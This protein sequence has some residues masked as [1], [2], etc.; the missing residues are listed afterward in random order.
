[1]KKIIMKTIAVVL[2]L[3]IAFFVVGKYEIVYA[4]GLDEESNI[5]EYETDEYR[6]TLQ[7]TSEWNTAYN[8]ILTAEN[9][10]LSTMHNWGMLYST[11]DNIVNP[12]NI[13]A[14]RTETGYILRNVGYNQDIPAK[15]TV[16]FGFTLFKNGSIRLPQNISLL[17]GKRVNGLNN[18]VVE[19]DII[20]AWDGGY[21]GQITITNSSSAPIE[22]WILFVENEDSFVTL[23]NGALIPIEDNQYAIFAPDDHQNILPG[24]SATVGYQCVGNTNSLKILDLF[25]QKLDIENGTEN[26]NTDENNGNDD[27]Q[28]TDNNDGTVCE[29]ESGDEYFYIQ[30]D[31]FT[32]ADGGIITVKESTDTISGVCSYD[33]V[34]NV[35]LEVYDLY[36]SIIF[37]NE[38]TLSREHWQSE[39]GLVVGYNR[40]VFKINQVDGSLIKTIEV[41]N[42]SEENSVNTDIDLSDSDDD[43]VA[44]YYESMFGTD[45][46]NPDTDGDGLTD[47]EEIIFSGTDPLLSDTDGNGI[48]DADEDTDGDELTILDE[49]KFGTSVFYSDTDEDGLSDGYEV[50]TSKTDPTTYDTDG[51]G[52]SD[53]E[54]IKLG[55]NPLCADSD[56][57]GVSD[58]EEFI[59][60]EKIYDFEGDG[61]LDS[62]E[63]EL[64]CQGSVEGNVFIRDMINLDHISTDLVGLIGSP[65]EIDAMVDFDEATIQF[66][67]D[68]SKLN[69]TNEDDLCLMWYDDENR[70]YV[71]LEDSVVDSINNTVSYTTTH[72]SKYMIVDKKLWLQTMRT[73]ISYE[74]MGKTLV[75]ENN[76][77]TVLV[78]YTLSY[79]EL[80]EEEDLIRALI[81]KWEDGDRAFIGY[82]DAYGSYT[83]CYPNGVVEWKDNKAD[84]LNVVSKSTINDIFAISTG[85]YNPTSSTYDGAMLSALQTAVFPY[86][87]GTTSGNK[88]VAYIFYSGNVPDLDNEQV[89]SEMAACISEAKTNG[90]VINTV[91]MG[92]Y[93]NPY[94]DGLIAQT[95]GKSYLFIDAIGVKTDYDSRLSY[96]G[97]PVDTDGDGIPDVYEINGVRIQNG[98]IVYTDPNKADTD[99]D[100]VS[101]FEEM[102]GCVYNKEY[103]GDGPEVEYVTMYSDPNDAGSNGR[104]LD[105]EYI[106]VTEEMGGFDY[107]PLS[108]KQKKLI[109][110]NEISPEHSV[111]TQG[112]RIHGRNNIYKSNI[113]ELTKHEGLEIASKAATGAIMAKPFTSLASD[114]LIYYLWNVCDFNYFNAVDVLVTRPNKREFNQGMYD[115]LIAGIN[116]IQKG[117]TITIAIAPGEE[118][119]GGF[120]MGAWDAFKSPD[121]FFAIKACEAR[122][123]LKLSFDGEKYTYDLKYYIYDYYD[124]DGTQD[125]RLVL[126][127]TDQQLFKLCRK[128]YAKFY[129]NWGLYETKSS[130]D[131]SGDIKSSVSEKIKYTSRN[132]RWYDINSGMPTE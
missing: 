24:E 114:F 129:Q 105:A 3:A 16:S 4:S 20:N 121:S 65:I 51:D 75:S 73:R 64:S 80:L 23:W 109:Y 21:I 102:G 94:L 100:G 71:L 11:V 130:I 36:D 110:E 78:D 93:T 60:Q 55:L 69:G 74:N 68:E 97:T 119:I 57:D 42:F 59:Q 17:Y 116:Y 111:D 103:Y 56:G 48:F 13:T 124:W 35:Q 1:M 81:N 127:V 22:D 84:A 50:K 77:L 44:N 27:N 70:K 88:K 66:Q 125:T 108:N 37:E 28:N 31:K 76:D 63:V 29:F 8:V 107:L 14:E 5:K 34:K 25:E 41:F 43:G 61:V 122:Q 32:Q 98:R 39:I 18:A 104:E 52:Y 46:M 19:N 131:I 10:T 49:I 30:D 72:F 90:I 47:L 117:E 54:E 123:V 9:K 33:D 38:L 113:N 53:G 87:T 112:N 45:K 120:D 106:L 92:S 67:Y 7:V 128:G 83:K 95:G 82:Y 58:A 89:V 6:I 26:N 91:S 126:P 85:Q 2:G 62:V 115:I 40:L 101:D 86:T 118:G 79:S 12:Y 132:L 96:D 99:D 15:G